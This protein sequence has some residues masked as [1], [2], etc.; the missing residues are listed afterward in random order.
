MIARP[1]G[2]E[3]EI[4]IANSNGERMGFELVSPDEWK[5]RDADGRY[6]FVS[7]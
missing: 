1:E 6:E 2:G 7:G 3:Q 5:D 4:T